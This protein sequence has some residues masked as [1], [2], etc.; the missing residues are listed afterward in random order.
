MITSAAVFLVVL[1]LLRRRRSP[2]VVLA[3]PAAVLTGLAF[4]RAGHRARPPRSEN[5][6]GF[7]ALQ[8][9]LIMPMFLF[10]GTFFPVEPAAG[11]P[12]AG[13]LR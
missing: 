12:A 10:S 3:L 5:D 4:A 2:L 11:R 9:F 13:R 6:S 8:R 1:V 7:A